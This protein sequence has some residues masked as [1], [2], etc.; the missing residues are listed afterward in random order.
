M[1]EDRPNAKETRW[2]QRF[3]NL[4]KA[5]ALLQEA[6]E[7]PSLSRLEEEGLIQRFEYT[8]ELCWKTM[9]DYLEAGGLDVR[10]PRDVLKEAYRTGLVSDGEAWLEMLENRNLLAHTYDDERFAEALGRVRGRFF[11]AM[12]ELVGRLEAEA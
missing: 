11:P 5:Y 3:H 6:A 8:F 12:R 9:K 10:L 1:S 7:A 4:S 2:R